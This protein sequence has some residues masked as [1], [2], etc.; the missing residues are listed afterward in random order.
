MKTAEIIENM[1]TEMGI[2]KADLAKKMGMLP[3]SGELSGAFAF[4]GAGAQADLLL[5]DGVEVVDGRVD[6]R[7]YGIN[8]DT[9]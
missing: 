7:K 2:T 5:E 9:V 4:G 1:C 3:S 8:V 6:L